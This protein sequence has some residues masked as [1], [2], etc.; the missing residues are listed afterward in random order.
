MRIARSSNRKLNHLCKV[1][2]KF[3]VM[4]VRDM[5]LETKHRLKDDMLLRRRKVAF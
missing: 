1:G 4:N 3:M 5:P 2:M